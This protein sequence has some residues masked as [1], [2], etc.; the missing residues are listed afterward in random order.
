MVYVCIDSGDCFDSRYLDGSDATTNFEHHPP[1][2]VRTRLIIGP[3]RG[4]SIANQ[5]K[6]QHFSERKKYIL[7]SYR[8]PNNLLWFQRTIHVPWVAIELFKVT[9][10]YRK[11]G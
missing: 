7:D 5:R 3:G 11:K 2:E 8:P 1:L 10:T 6:F 4:T 9:N